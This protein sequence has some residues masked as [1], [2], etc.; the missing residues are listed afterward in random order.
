MSPRRNRL[1]PTLL[2]VPPEIKRLPSVS[3]PSISGLVKPLKCRSFDRANPLGSRSPPSC[4]VRSCTRVRSPS[5]AGV[6]Y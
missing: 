2:A 3:L 5:A 4:G 6:S 1:A